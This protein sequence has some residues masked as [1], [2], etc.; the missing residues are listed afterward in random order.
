MLFFVIKD[1]NR[2][3]YVYQFSLKW[4]MEIFEAELKAEDTQEAGKPKV[5]PVIDLNDRLTQA[6]Y[7]KV[8][9]SVFQKDKLLISFMIA[10]AWMKSEAN[11]DQNLVKF[12]IQGPYKIED[13]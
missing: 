9:L 6:V 2:L 12:F 13:T 7:Q 3:E 5:D 10:H 8:C 11:I 1:L 4:F